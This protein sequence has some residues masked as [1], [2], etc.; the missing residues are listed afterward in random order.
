[1]NVM[2]SKIADIL[3]RR[4]GGNDGNYSHK[5]GWFL[6]IPY[7]RDSFGWTYSRILASGYLNTNCIAPGEYKGKKDF[8]RFLPKDLTRTPVKGPKKENGRHLSASFYFRVETSVYTKYVLDIDERECEV[9]LI[10]RDIV[11]Y[12]HAS[13]LAI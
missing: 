5:R 3:L 8:S 2:P 6:L 13:L 12:S 11:I 1:M 4:Y 10:L 9:Y 7:S